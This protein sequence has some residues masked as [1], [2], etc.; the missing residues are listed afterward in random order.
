MDN[1][2]SSVK[3]QHYVPACYLAN[4][5]IDGNK[6]RNSKLYFF[7]TQNNHFGIANANAFP[8]EKAFYDIDYLGEN[9]QI[10]EKVFSFIEGDYASLLKEIIALNIENREKSNILPLSKDSKD[11]LAACFAIQIIRTKEFRNYF[12]YMYS[13]M[14]LSI[15]PKYI[16]DYNDDDFKKI[17]N[18]SILISRESNFYANLFSDRKW[19]FLINYTDVPFITSDNPCIQI[20]HCDSAKPISPVSEKVTHYIP[21]SPNLAIEIY[22][23]EIKPNDLSYFHIYKKS[24]VN[25]YNLNIQNQCTFFLFSNE[26]IFIDKTESKND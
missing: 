6:G 5:G 17:H 3:N 15:P 13:Q 14:K 19:I 1:M 12:K 23:K 11:K 8:K 18:M 2:Q 21:I 25:W 9:S 20:N 10:I 16:P 24:H 22:D 7:N 26:N 4:F